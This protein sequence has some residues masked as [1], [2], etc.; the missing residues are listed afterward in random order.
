MNDHQKETA[1]LRQCILYDDTEER[2]RLEERITQILRDERIVRR[3]VWLMAL[4]SALAMAGLGYAAVFMVDYPL[5]VSQLTTRLLIKG[6]CAL[7]GGSV[8]CLLVFL[9]LG[10]VF[11]KELDQRRE[12]CRRLALKVLESRLGLPRVLPPAEIAKALEPILDGNR[13]VI[14]ANRSPER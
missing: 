12:D 9:G 13:A 6:L 14:E 11:R 5:N 4:L 1:F 8:I 7:G 2:H 10:A 3:A